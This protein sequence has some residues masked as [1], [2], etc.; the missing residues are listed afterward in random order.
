MYDL[1]R[2]TAAHQSD[3]ATALAE[4]R[5][6]CKTSH[7]M[8]YIF[9]QLKGLGRSST[10]MYYGIDS[11]DEAITF[12]AD[13]YLGGHLRE[14]TQALMEL[15]QSDPTAIFGRPDDMKLR[16]CMTLFACAAPDETLFQDVIDWY[17]GGRM[18]NRTLR[19]LG[20]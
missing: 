15:G 13:P 16:S 2:F 11:I 6:G 14:I 5:N 17:F 9:P 7:W 3:Y 12:L 18:D 8:W 19:M 1:S 4:I 10:S 20:R